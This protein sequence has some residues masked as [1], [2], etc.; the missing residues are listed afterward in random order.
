MLKSAGNLVASAALTMASANA[1]PFHWYSYFTPSG[2]IELA[3]M[4][5]ETNRCSTVADR[6]KSEVD[7]F[8]KLVNSDE[9]YTDA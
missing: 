1:S 3:K 8:F 2:V 9:Q 5:L 7:D 6:N 4:A